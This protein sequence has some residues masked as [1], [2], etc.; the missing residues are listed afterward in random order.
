MPKATA[1]LENR[2]PRKLNSAR[3]DDRDLRRQRVRVDDR[4]D[5]V[6]RVVEAVDELEAERDQ[7]RHA[8]QQ[9][10]QHARVAYFLQVADQ[11]GHDVDGSRR[12]SR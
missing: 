3:P 1:P 6:R 4:R 2:T 7:Q 8:E 5:R 12:Q 10:R 9:E 11:V